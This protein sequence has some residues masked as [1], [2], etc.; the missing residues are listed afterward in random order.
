MRRLLCKTEV[1]L[2]RTSNEGGL[3]DRQRPRHRRRADMRGSE[4]GRTSC[5]RRARLRAPEPRGVPGRGGRRQTCWS[6]RY[7]GSVGADRGPARKRSGSGPDTARLAAG[8][9]RGAQCRLPQRRPGAAR[10]CPADR[11]AARPAG[12]DPLEPVSG[13]SG[14]RAPAFLLNDYG[15]RHRRATLLVQMIDLEGQPHVRSGDS[16]CDGRFRASIFS[17]VD[18]ERRNPAGSGDVRCRGANGVSPYG[19]FQPG[20]AGWRRAI[21]GSE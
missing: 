19:A 8:L 4:S 20:L 7:A 9:P 6:R 15:R 10:P 12:R 3:V 1:L 17:R 11:P 18:R 2:Y 21:G 13:S 14:G 16:N 5:H